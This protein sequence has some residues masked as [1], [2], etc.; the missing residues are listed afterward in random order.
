MLSLLASAG[1]QDSVLLSAFEGSDLVTQSVA[2]RIPVIL[3]HELEGRDDLDIITLEDIHQVGGWSAEIY[4]AS[5]PRGQYPGCS[6]VVAQS[7][8]AHYAVTG[9]VRPAE[10]SEA[11]AA[12]ESQPPESPAKRGDSLAVQASPLPETTPLIQAEV[13]IY[14]L[15]VTGEKDPVDL[16][17][18]YEASDE[19]T[20]THDVL[21]LLD[22]LISGEVGQVID[23]RKEPEQP[24]DDGEL[25]ARIKELEELEQEMGVVENQPGGEQSGPYREHRARYSLDRVVTMED[26]PWE[27]MGLT[28]REYTQW[29]NSGWDIITWREMNDGRLGRFLLRPL[30]G[31]TFGFSAE[32]YHARYALE[33]LKLT[34]QEVYAVQSLE[35]GFGPSL[36]LSGGYG[37]SSRTEM[38][39]A[40]MLEGGSYDTDIDQE[41]YHSEVDSIVSETSY[42]NMLKVLLGVRYSPLTGLTWRP[43][44]GAGLVYARGT[45]VTAHVDLPRP[46]LP[47][48]NAPNLLAARLMGG[49][50]S[51]ITR[52][53]DFF[54]QVPL[55][56]IVLGGAAQVHDEGA[57]YLE[58]KEDPPYAFPLA[59]ALQA[60]LQFRL[61]ATPAGQPY[62]QKNTSAEDELMLDD[63]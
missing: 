53:M 38:E 22:E 4:M 40:V 17:F 42:T 21:F 57:R 9:M 12:D 32:R 29:W 13:E 52:S 45:K 44:A 59:A 36:G 46:E 27:D 10:A 5:C 48:L 14:L 28:P 30:L 11:Q 41:I 8:G 61:G 6:L 31:A 2:A 35:A 26:Q 19:A 20:F 16:V 50:E 34:V 39:F 33:P 51:R 37:L 25:Q 47:V 1:A 60:G 56:V 55:D 3:A 49:M 23:I 24:R 43:I 58:N 62:G 7:G 63:Y 54:L 15:D 18:H